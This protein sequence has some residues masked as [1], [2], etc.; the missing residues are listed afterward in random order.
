MLNINNICLCGKNSNII[1]DGHTSEMICKRCGVVMRR[2]NVM[3]EEITR[4]NSTKTCPIQKPDNKIIQ[5]IPSIQNKRVLS[6]MLT[7]RM[8]KKEKCIQNT[9]QILD[10]QF[11][12]LNMTSVIK[13]DAYRL[14]IQFSKK[15]YYR[16]HTK[17]H[18]ICAVC[19]Y[20]A[21]RINKRYINSRTLTKQLGIPQKQFHRMYKMLSLESDVVIPVNI[22]ELV[23]RHA[24]KISTDLNLS[25]GIVECALT[26]YKMIKPY[27]VTEGKE[28]RTVASAIIWIVINN[29]PKNK[30]INKGILLKSANIAPDSMSR[31]INEIRMSVPNIE[32]SLRIHAGR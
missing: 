28:P 4:T 5:K 18:I 29:I 23:F 14:A 27:H 22:D 32:T 19:I 11:A 8:T 25:R 1:F 20:T 17:H 21:F 15:N 12:K 3:Q 30:R 10:E 24:N 31:L 7:E 26:I 2:D 6:K 9:H 16:M 13:E